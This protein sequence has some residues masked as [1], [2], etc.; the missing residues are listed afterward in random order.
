MLIATLA[1]RL[2]I[3]SLAARA[4]RLGQ[5][6]GAAIAGRKVMTLIFAMV[7]GADCIDDCDVLRSGRLSM[8]LGRVAAPSTLGTFLRAFTFGHVRQLDRL[9]GE[10]L[11]RAWRAG[12]GPG[13]ERLVI[14]VDSSI[15]ELY[16]IAKQGA[17]VNIDG[18]RERSVLPRSSNTLSQQLFLTQASCLDVRGRSEGGGNRAEEVHRSGRP[19][20]FSAAKDSTRTDPIWRGFCAAEDSARSAL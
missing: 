17:A 11:T 13:A 6:V 20:H 3:E 18:S 14:D 7:L 1:E 19:C 15:G 9:L 8:L 12:A 4:V 10:V 2:G 5:R 16:G